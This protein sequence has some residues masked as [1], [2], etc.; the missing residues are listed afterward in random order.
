MLPQ[1]LFTV[2]FK[3]LETT[4]FNSTQILAQTRPILNVSPL[5]SQ[6]PSSHPI[7]V[8][9]ICIHCSISYSA[10]VWVKVIAVILQPRFDLGN[11]VYIITTRAPGYNDNSCTREKSGNIYLSAIR[12]CLL[13]GYEFYRLIL[14][15]AVCYRLVAQFGSLQ[16]SAFGDDKVYLAARAFSR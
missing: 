10:L 5:S 6:R 9:I 12:R 8:I 11:R 7:H 14:V 4:D 13:T 3:M 15:H 2:V 16:T 1:Q